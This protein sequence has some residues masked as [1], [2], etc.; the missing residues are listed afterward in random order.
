MNPLAP[1]PF[2]G[3]RAWIA[4]YLERRAVEG[5]TA[6]KPHGWVTNDGRPRCAHCGRS[7]RDAEV[8]IVLYD[9]AACADHRAIVRKEIRANS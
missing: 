9:I 1:Q 2:A 4:S 8:A 5:Q 6:V 7:D 3:W